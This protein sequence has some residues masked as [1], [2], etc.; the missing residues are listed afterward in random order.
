MIL[1]CL[2]GAIVN[3]EL[4]YWCSSRAQFELQLS[5]EDAQSASQ[6]GKDADEDVRALIAL[7]YVAE[8]LERID[9]ALLASELEEHGAWDA[10]ELADHEA[11]LRRLVWIA[12]CDISQEQS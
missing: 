8:Q 9:A 2:R 1:G 11:N 7:P 3:N 4:R 6:P 12:S 10:E 5:L